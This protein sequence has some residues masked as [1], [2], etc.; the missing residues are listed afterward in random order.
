[1]IW[2][3]QEAKIFVQF[4][5][6]LANGTVFFFFFS[7]QVLC[8]TTFP[9]ALF[10]LI[11]GFLKRDLSCSRHAMSL[12]VL[13]WVFAIPISLLNVFG[14]YLIESWCNSMV[15]CIDLCVCEL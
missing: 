9:A 10:F 3:T 6:R 8:L 1:M 11:L 4:D 13:F 5:N 14:T 15:G 2:A 12:S 7:K